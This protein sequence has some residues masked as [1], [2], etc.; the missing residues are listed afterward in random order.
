MPLWPVFANWPGN[1]EHCWADGEPH[2]ATCLAW[3]QTQSLVAKLSQAVCIIFTKLSRLH[4]QNQSLAVVRWVVKPD[5]DPC[6]PSC[7]Q[8]VSC[9]SESLNG[10]IIIH[11]VNCNDGQSDCTRICWKFRKREIVVTVFQVYTR[12]LWGN[13]RGGCQMSHWLF[14]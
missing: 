4:Q 10:A 2:R 9:C 3:L 13:G 5:A 8:V 6:E 14:D 7:R 12:T 1:S 11:G